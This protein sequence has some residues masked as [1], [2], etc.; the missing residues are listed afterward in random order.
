MV[1]TKRDENIR[2]VEMIIDNKIV[3]K[4][5]NKLWDKILNLKG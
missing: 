2:K 4:S 1:K 3:I 5:K